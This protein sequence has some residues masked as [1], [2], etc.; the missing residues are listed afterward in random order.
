V[1]FFETLAEAG[2]E[3]GGFVEGGADTNEREIW[4]EFDPNG[5]VLNS[6]LYW[7]VDNRPANALHWIQSY[8]VTIGQWDTLMTTI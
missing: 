1:E 2:F 5:Y 3:Q 8:E 6:E 7:T 4:A